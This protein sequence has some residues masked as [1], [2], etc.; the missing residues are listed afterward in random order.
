MP[1]KDSGYSMFTRLMEKNRNFRS[2]LLN[3]ESRK[4]VPTQ[5][6]VIDD[7]GNISLDNGKKAYVIH[8]SIVR[9]SQIDRWI[10]PQQ[11]A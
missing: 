2:D 10:T 9:H 8:E 7:E 1:K 4:K 11:T 6:L 5:S 3:K